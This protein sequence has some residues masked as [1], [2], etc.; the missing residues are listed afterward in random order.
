MSSHPENASAPLPVGKLPW[1]LLVLGAVPV[2]GTAMLAAR[3][4]WEQTLWTW[5]RG[6]QMVGFS[7]VHGS[8]AILLL[9]PILVLWITAVA[10]V[11]V[12]MIIR[13][14]R[15][16]GTTWLALWLPVI[17]FTL[18]L[19][20]EG[21]WERLFI[22]QMS[23]SYYAADLVK[24]AIY[25]GDLGTVRAMLSH[26]VPVGAVEHAQWRTPLHTAAGAGN[27]R[28]VR[29]LLLKGADVNAL[30]RSG[31]SPAELGASSG[32]PECVAF[33]QEHGGRRIKGDE[34]QHQKAIED[35]VRDDIER[36]DRARSQ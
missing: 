3:L 15:V 26:G 32:H 14:R 24:Y 10:A 9:P 36:M 7:L 6:P 20:P 11:I 21:F 17:V 27:L 23:R 35:E 8:G 33:L 2:A 29:F 28:I 34:A 19:L 12:W 1:W 4:I 30:D 5:E 25:R 13:K 31:D 16:A 18:L 22:R